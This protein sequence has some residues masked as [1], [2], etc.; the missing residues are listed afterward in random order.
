MILCMKFIRTNTPIAAVLALV[1]GFS[2][3]EC[4]ALAGFDPDFESA[5]ARA[6]ENGKPLFAL[7]TGSDWCPWCIKLA[8]EVFSKP[9]FLDVATNACEL[10]IVDFPQNPSGQTDGERRR[11]RM[12]LGMYGIEGFPTVVLLGADGKEIHRGGYAPGGA[13][14][15]IEKFMKD[16]GKAAEARKQPQQDDAS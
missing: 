11:N 14:A 15:W 13:K 4:L 9:E 16:A 2:A 5:A 12:L 10:A 8:D 1:A 3:V 7:F 6:K